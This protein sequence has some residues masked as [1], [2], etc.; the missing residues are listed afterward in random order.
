MSSFWFSLFEYFGFFFFQSTIHR[1]LLIAITSLSS[2]KSRLQP[3]LKCNSWW[4]WLCLPNNN[5]LNNRYFRI[6]SSPTLRTLLSQQSL[7]WLQVKLM[8]VRTVRLKI[9]LL[10]ILLQTYHDH[11]K[12]QCER[13]CWLSCIAC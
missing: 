6:C 4:L 7:R 10:V 1:C 8:Q 12:K 2:F 3:F 13:R 11:A 9:S 5:L